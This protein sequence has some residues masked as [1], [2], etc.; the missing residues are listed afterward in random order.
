VDPLIHM[1]P[2]WDYDLAFGNA[3]YL[4]AFNTYGW[5]YTVPA[6]GWGTPFWWSRFMTDPYYANYLN[7]YWHSLRQ[8]VLSNDSLI[9]IIDSTV[10]KIGPA[11][12]RNFDRWPIL[13]QYVW[14][15]P[16]VGNTYEEDINYMKNWI[17]DRAAWIDANIPGVYCTTGIDDNEETFTLS[18]RA[19]PNPAVG[20]IN[21]EVQ[22][23]LGEK[24]SMEV[25]NLTGQNVYSVVIENETMY[26]ETIRLQPGIY[27]VHVSGVNGIKTTKFIIQ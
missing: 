24:L 23:P 7:C 14:P 19:Y 26:T 10:A 2:V 5:N 13:G 8:T 6:D 22:N 27:V 1:G 25:S 9:A 4:E 17:L 16:Y 12:D 18:L 11:S 3:N 21:L 20:Q 15:N